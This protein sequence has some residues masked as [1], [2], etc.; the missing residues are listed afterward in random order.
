MSNLP[1]LN[2]QSTGAAA[3]EHAPHCCSEHQCT[4]PYVIGAGAGGACGADGSGE[5]Q[6]E[7]HRCSTDNVAT[8]IDQL[9][10]RCDRL[11]RGSD[12]RSTTFDARGAAHAQSVATR[13]QERSNGA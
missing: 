13:D 2:H 10:A 6:S 9:L 7:L 1:K 5:D 11:T 3:L 12:M 8:R 4:A